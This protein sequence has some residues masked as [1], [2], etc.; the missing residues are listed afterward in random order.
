LDEPGEEALGLGKVLLDGGFDGGVW[1]HGAFG[2]VRCQ[3]SGVGVRGSGFGVQGS[4]F[5][6]F[7]IGYPVTGIGIGIG[8]GLRV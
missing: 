4:G 7:G 2:G 3:V 5:G 8:I 1:F 6:E